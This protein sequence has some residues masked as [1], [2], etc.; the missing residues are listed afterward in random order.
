MIQLKEVKDVKYITNPVLQSMLKYTDENEVLSIV[1]VIHNE[2]EKGM[3]VLRNN[4]ETN[5]K[6]YGSLYIYNDAFALYKEKFEQP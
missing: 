6:Y 5:P 4:K 2:E 3:F 1:L